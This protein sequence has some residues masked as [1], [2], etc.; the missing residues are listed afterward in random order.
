MLRIRIPPSIDAEWWARVE[1]KSFE[2]K[3]PYARGC[4]VLHV[5][6]PSASCLQVG[7]S[8][9]SR[10]ALVFCENELS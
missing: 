3:R 4:F 6:P 9:P 2:S 7:L 10:V 5:T 8:V 1:G